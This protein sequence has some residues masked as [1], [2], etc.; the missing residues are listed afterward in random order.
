MRI[1]DELKQLK[2]FTSEHEKL[3]VNILFTAS[4]LESLSIQRFKPF[5]ISPQQYNVLRI[6]RGSAPNAVMLGE[7][8]CR[9]I[10]KNSNATRLVEKLRIKGFVK[11][12]I[13]SSNRRQVDIIITKKGLELLEEIDVNT[14]NWNDSL[15]KLPQPDAILMNDFLDKMRS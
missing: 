3:V 15:L 8:A 2:K 10:D 9:M 4:W 13:C 6:L 7:I 11:R 5:G 14:H 12:E 1:E